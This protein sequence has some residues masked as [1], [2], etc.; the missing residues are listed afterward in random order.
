MG[1]YVSL[2]SDWS[3]VRRCGH[4]IHENGARGVCYCSS[5][6]RGSWAR[7]EPYGSQAMDQDQAATS[8]RRTIPSTACVTTI[9]QLAR[10]P[11]VS[12]NTKRAGR[13][14]HRSKALQ[15]F[16]CGRASHLPIVGPRALA[17]R[18]QSGKRHSAKG[19]HLA[20]CTRPSSDTHTPG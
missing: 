18:W 14:K 15:Q 11:C 19:L 12:R 1:K 20:K 4:E 3:L 17:P 8:L 2:G 6:L 16:D 13:K 7:H 5:S 10:M 9:S